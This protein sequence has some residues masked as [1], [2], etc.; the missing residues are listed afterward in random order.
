MDWVMFFVLLLVLLICA[1][2][3]TVPVTIVV[4]LELRSFCYNIPCELH[5]SIQK[6]GI[7]MH[8]HYCDSKKKNM[9]AG[10]SNINIQVQGDH[11][12][13]KNQ[14]RTA[15]TGRTDI[16]TI[17]HSLRMII[18]LING[19]KIKSAT[20]REEHHTLLVLMNRSVRIPECVDRRRLRGAVTELKREARLKVMFPTSAH[21]IGIC[22][23]GVD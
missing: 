7:I 16:Y 5:L 9:K 3:T 13:I 18:R 11:L 22:E 19:D 12:F 14:E 20:H 1:L 23:R 17:L 4:C 8:F 15:E 6:Q 21:D 10:H 2:S